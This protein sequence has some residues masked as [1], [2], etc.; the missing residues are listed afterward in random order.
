MLFKTYYKQNSI[1]C[2]YRSYFKS[3][4]DVEMMFLGTGGGSPSVHTNT[5]P[6]PV[7]PLVIGMS[8]ISVN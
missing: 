4:E 8:L 6:E 1:L 2:I 5:L 3:D 7:P